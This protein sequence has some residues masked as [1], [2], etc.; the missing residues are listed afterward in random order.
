MVLAFFGRDDGR[1]S[2]TTQFLISKYGNGLDDNPKEISKIF[3]AW[4]FVL[5]RNGVC[6]GSNYLKKL[7]GYDAIEIRVKNSRTLIRFPFFL[8]NINDRIV[9][10]LGFAKPE[11]YSKGGKI[12]REVTR[13]L[14]ESQLYYDEYKIDNNKYNISDDILLKFNKL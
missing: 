12:D 3:Q 13:K 9:L 14:D 2:P 10:L 11:Q 5:L 8:D 6:D 1:P 4:K 7:S